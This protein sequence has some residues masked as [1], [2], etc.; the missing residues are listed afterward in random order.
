MRLEVDAMLRGN[1]VLVCLL[2]SLV[3]L[4][5]VETN[6]AQVSTAILIGTVEDQSGAVLPNVVVTITNAERNTSR[7]LRTDELGGYIAHALIPG[8]YSISADLPGFKRF[9]QD[10]ITLHVNQIAHL[11]VRLEIGAVEESVRVSEGAQLLN[12]ETSS[13]G[14]VLDQQKILELPLNGRDYNQLATLSPGVL[15]STPRL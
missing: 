2:I 14:A 8:N 12:I 6:I 4:V 11:D 10:G 9:V 13:R 5:R 15:P 7:S 1:I 3:V